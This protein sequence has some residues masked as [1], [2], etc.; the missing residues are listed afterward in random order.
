MPIIFMFIKLGG[1]RSFLGDGDT[2]WHIRT[3]EWIL[4][5]H[6]VPTSI[7]FPSAG[8]VRHGSPGN[9]F[10]CLAAML[11]QH[12]GMAAVV[13]G[14]TLVT[15]FTSALLF[16]LARRACDN[17]F[18]AIAVTLLA[19]G[20]CAI[21]W[22]ARPHLFTMLF[23]TVTL[24]LTMRHAKA[25]SA[26]SAGWFLSL[27]CG[28]ICTA[29]FSWSFGSRL[30][31]RIRSAECADRARRSS[32]PRVSWRRT[33]VACSVRRLFCCDFYQPVRMESAPARHRIHYRSLSTAAH[34]GVPVDGLPFTRSALFRAAHAAFH[35]S[36][37][38]DL[39]RRR[40]ADVFLGMGFLHLSL[41]AQRNLP[42]SLSPPPPAGQNPHD[43]HPCGGRRQFE[44]VDPESRRLVPRR[45]PQL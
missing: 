40:F 16:R 6:Q 19:T 14:S 10:G 13:L 29:A 31:H 43:D 35:R 38:S 1:A 30:L 15:C 4:A 18:V 17:G 44:P 42:C 9:G 33:T 23:L 45:Q 21:H 32:A 36:A 27:F 37:V 25:E 28:P 34:R 26:C 8:L 3:G 24:H 7:S 12:W 11:F 41:L 22:L 39:T 2:G 5:H 20:G